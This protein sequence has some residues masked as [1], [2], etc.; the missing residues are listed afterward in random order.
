[1]ADFTTAPPTALKA[2]DLLKE[3]HPLY[4][5]FTAWAKTKGQEPTI[6]QGRKFLAAHPF[7]R[8]K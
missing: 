3:D 7:Y 2:A 5:S 1:M 4:R 8:R 6:R